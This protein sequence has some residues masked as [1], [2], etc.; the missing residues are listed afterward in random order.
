M[1]EDDIDM[2]DD[3]FWSPRNILERKFVKLSVINVLTIE[4]SNCFIELLNSKDQDNF[5][6]AREA[7]RTLSK[8]NEEKLKS[9]SS[10]IMD[11]VNRVNN[12]NAICNPNP[13]IYD[14]QKLVETFIN[15][16]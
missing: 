13:I 7:Y 6:I 14:V 8:G 9:V 2:Y 5:K 15:D 12:F 3:S 11:L 4:E 10:E 1:K 16:K